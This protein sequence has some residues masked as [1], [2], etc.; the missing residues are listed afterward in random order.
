[1]SK[2]HVS[3][4]RSKLA[5][6]CSRRPSCFTFSGASD[7]FFFTLPLEE[8]RTDAFFATGA[9][10]KDDAK[11]VSATEAE[12][13][14]EL[15]VVGSATSF[16]LLLV[17]A[18]SPGDAVGAT[19]FGGAV[20]DLGALTRMLLNNRGCE[21]PRAAYERLCAANDGRSASGEESQPKRVCNRA[22]KKERRLAVET[23]SIIHSPL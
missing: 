3:T 14:D 7:T 18:V 20:V 23:R 8:E 15:G 17:S 19:S 10:D 22:K 12:G 13:A 1:M 21:V 5:H 2:C 9:D 6:A 4:L 16:E 11:G